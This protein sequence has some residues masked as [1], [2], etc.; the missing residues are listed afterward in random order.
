MIS[1]EVDEVLGDDM[2]DLSWTRDEKCTENDFILELFKDVAKSRVSQTKC[3]A[4]PDLSGMADGVVSSVN[5]E[6]EASKPGDEPR[7]EAFR[8]SGAMRFDRGVYR[9]RVSEGAQARVF[10]DGQEVANFARHTSSWSRSQELSGSHEIR[11]EMPRNIEFKKVTLEVTKSTACEK[12]E[13]TVDF[14]SAP[15]WGKSG[16]GQWLGMSCQSKLDRSAASLAPKGVPRKALEDGAFVTRATATLQFEKGS[17]RIGM[18]DGGGALLVDNKLVA[19]VSRQPGASQLRFSDR[20][21]QLNG[22]HEFSY[23]W[24]AHSGIMRA[25]WSQVPVCGEGQWLAQFFRTQEEAS[26]LGAECLENSNSK[27]AVVPHTF[28]A[29]F[30]ASDNADGSHKSVI[31]PKHGQDT[32]KAPLLVRASSVGKLQS[33]RYRFTTTGSAAR[34]AFDGQRVPGFAADGFRS[35]SRVLTEGQHKVTAQFEAA[36]GE[37]A[38]LVL[39]SDPNCPDGKLRVEWFWQEFYTAAG[40]AW[41]VSCHTAE[42]LQKGLPEKA[43]PKFKAN[44]GGFSVSIS[45]R[46]NFKK[47]AYRFLGSTQGAV[48][49]T[50][51][52]VSVI[53]FWS[54]AAKEQKQWSKS[55]PLSGFHDV[56]FEFHESSPEPS[57]HLAWEETP[58]CGK[59]NW[60]VEYF[61]R[62]DVEESRFVTQQCVNGA[63][64]AGQAQLDFRDNALPEGLA[65]DF[66]IK[67]T[68]TCGFES[69]N[70]IFTIPS[71]QQ[72]R[73][74]VDNGI[75]LDASLNEDKKPEAS[76]K[77]TLMSAGDH[78]VVLEQQ[79]R[80]VASAKVSWSSLK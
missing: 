65:G 60:L 31:W 33:G 9:F 56:R 53:D 50:V 20:A 63:T 49:G 21:L 46:V 12:G 2:V 67:A 37:T 8:A 48:K 42:D 59:C 64:A 35:E 10:V 75:L 14:Y 30:A 76:S 51:D 29:D 40:D 18:E 24:N 11:V 62:S 26:F 45:G 72:G 68:T 61:Q 52:G 27:A 70:Y 71:D 5:L 16:V 19:D 25:F 55:M 57:A 79:E 34:V 54:K 6:L 44:H 41:S 77:S 78:T 38:S 1:F 13:W 73:V 36:V 3:V 23:E 32:S 28:S 80:S 7:F 66:S 58:E 43:L 22:D 17:Y 39:A 15:A 4:T 74:T 69:G 47:G